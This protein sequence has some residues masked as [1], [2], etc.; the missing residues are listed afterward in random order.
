MMMIYYLMVARGKI[1][2]PCQR[3]ARG[4]LTIIGPNR[5]AGG[6]GK[7]ALCVVDGL[8]VGPVQQP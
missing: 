5:N 1:C 8:W 6:E 7:E 2:N 4:L 3:T